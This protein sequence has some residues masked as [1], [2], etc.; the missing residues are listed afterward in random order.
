MNLFEVHT[1]DDHLCK[2][3]VA[4]SASEA[5]EIVKGHHTDIN[6][7]AFELTSDE[8]ETLKVDSIEVYVR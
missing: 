5:V 1:D 3:A 8:V 7:Y 4:N 2:W 6:W